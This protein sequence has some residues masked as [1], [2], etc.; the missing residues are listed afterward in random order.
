[1]TKPRTKGKTKK[2][3]YVPQ[4]LLR[5]FGHGKKLKEKL[6][7]LD[8][9]NASVFS[10]A[11][12]DAAHENKFYEYHC[13]AGSADFEKLT[14]KLDTKVA[15]IVSDV[16]RSRRLPRTGEN[17]IWLT[18]LVAAQMLRTPTSR[19]DMENVRELIIHKWGPEVA[20]EGDP[21]SIGEYGPEDSKISSIQ[22]LR[23]VPRFAK[24]LQEKVWCLCKAPVDSPFI[25]SDNPVTRH[26]MLDRWPR[27]NLGLENRGIE[28]YMLLSPRLS[29]Q[30]IC[31]SIAGAVL[32]TPE[33]TE[34]YGRAL[35]DE[36]PVKI[37]PENVE[38]T[39]S[40][41]VIWA[42]RF[43]Y[44]GDRDHLKMPLDMLRTNPELR[45]GPGTRQTHDEI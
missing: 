20:F 17:F 12:R 43:V 44:A 38:F 25:I 5:Q 23:D 9:R 32:L 42:E 45:A 13:E 27:G 21:R 11:V 18:Y 41:Q 36:E 37:R 3:H 2:Q 26:N 30:I 34:V 22:M 24:I 16:L 7:V 19:R 40:L 1:M 14:E 8:K 33:L 15:P 10:A 4:F 28:A 35:R 29:L 31:P 6:W 39:N